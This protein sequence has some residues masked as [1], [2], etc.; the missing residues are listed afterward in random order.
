MCHSAKAF[1]IIIVLNIEIYSTCVCVCVCVCVVA[2]AV[3]VASSVFRRA[4][5]ADAGKDFPFLVCDKS[6]DRHAI[7]C[8]LI[9]ILLMFPAK[10]T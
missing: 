3:V 7:D 5:T 10:E 9:H 2:V 6:N 8:I 1:V 4:L